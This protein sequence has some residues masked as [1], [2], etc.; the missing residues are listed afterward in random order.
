M[1]IKEKTFI[2]KKEINLS[3]VAKYVLN[4]LTLSKF[5]L[6]KGELGAGKT[7]LTKAIATELDIKE[8]VTSPTFNYL[9][10]YNNLI[11]IDAYNLRD[12]LDEFSDYFENKIVVVEWAENIYIDYDNFVDI[13]I[14]VLEDNSRKYKVKVIK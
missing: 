14:E 11:H 1:S 6:L 7:A 5:V 13:E 9:K 8:N 4:N 2:I 3:E 10:I 12:N